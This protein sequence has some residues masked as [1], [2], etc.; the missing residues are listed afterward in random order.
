MKQKIFISTTTFAEF[1]DAPLSRLKRAG[2]QVESNPYGRKLN[3]KECLL[4]YKDITAVIA[5]TERITRNLLEYASGLK[6]ISRCGTG[7]DNV[8]LEAASELGI[9]VFNTPDGP[10]LAVAELTVGLILGLLRRISE[11]DRN[12]REGLWEKKMGHLL[13]E[14]A[15]GIIGYG[16]IGRKVAELLRR[17]DCEVSFNDINVNGAP[18]GCRFLPLEDILRQSDVVCLHVSGNF[19]GNPLI[20]ENE[21]GIMKKGSW[22][23]NCSRGGVI[24]EAALY[25]ALSSKYLSGA[26]LDVFEEEPYRGRLKDLPNVILT[27]HIGSYA[28]EARI[29]MEEMAVANLLQGLQGL[30]VEGNKG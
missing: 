2:F 21:I 22:I 18:D 29:R 26:A 3:A 15:V 20:G 4:H 19:D 16:K 13:S 1:D 14:K 27:P 12:L 28:Q 24:D 7:I 10:T 9:R 5:G 23:V 8:D 17:L 25:N 30:N 6:V 11:M